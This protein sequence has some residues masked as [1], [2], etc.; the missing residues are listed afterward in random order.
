VLKQT[1]NSGLPH[2]ERAG[3]VVSM[4]A[5]YDGAAPSGLGG[6]EDSAHN[7][8]QTLSPIEKPSVSAI[9]GGSPLIRRY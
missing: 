2:M 1:A 6:W 8:Q 5:F 7:E 4:S 9:F 3:D